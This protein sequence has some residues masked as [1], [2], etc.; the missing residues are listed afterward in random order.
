MCRAGGIVTSIV[1]PDELP[2]VLGI[3]KQLGLP[4]PEV[5]DDIAAELAAAAELAGAAGGPDGGEPAL[6]KLQLG[7]EQL[8]KLRRGLEDLYNLM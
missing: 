6:G 3:C 5:D 2:H 1:T 8:G 4:P 7:D